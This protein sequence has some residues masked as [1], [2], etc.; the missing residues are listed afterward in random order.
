MG[1]MEWGGGGREGNLELL[2]PLNPEGGVN[3]KLHCLSPP[4]LR[5]TFLPILAQETTKLI[6]VSL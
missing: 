5:R 4:A 3:S 2:I 1:G 6:Y